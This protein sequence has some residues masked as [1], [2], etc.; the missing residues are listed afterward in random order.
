MNIENEK[1]VM[2]IN[3]KL[4]SGIIANT[5]AILGIT[6][7][8]KIPELIGS[9]V[10]DSNGNIHNGIIKIPIPVLRGNSEILRNIRQ[11]LFESEFS[12]L[13]TVDFTDL[14]Q[15]CKTYD[16]FT[17]KTANCEEKLLNYIGIAIC[18][19]KRK[20]NKLTGNLPLLK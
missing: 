1:C 2:I 9:E 3:E 4:P 20:I 15:S 19:D 18:G 17:E 8:K 13:I 7:G 14:A 12:T 5:A 16:E 10:I 11:K 6:I